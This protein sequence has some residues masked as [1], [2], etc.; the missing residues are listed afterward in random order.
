VAR[1]PQGPSG[2]KLIYGRN[3]PNLN[4]FDTGGMGVFGRTMRAQSGRNGQVAALLADA[5]AP[6]ARLGKRAATGLCPERGHLRA[7]V[8]PAQE[9][10]S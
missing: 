3:G 10:R 7:P 2:S 1:K 4:L 6:I 8:R 5:R 9:R